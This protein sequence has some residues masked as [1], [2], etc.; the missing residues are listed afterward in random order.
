[1]VHVAT[2]GAVFIVLWQNI[3]ALVKKPFCKLTLMLIVATI[4]ACLLVVLAGDSIDSLL[5]GSLLGP[6]FI[7][8]SA[9]ICFSEVFSAVRGRVRRKTI[10][11]AVRTDGKGPLCDPLGGSP[12]DINLKSALTIGVLQA[13]AILPGV[14]R[15][16][17]TLAGG[18]SLGLERGVSARFS[19]LLSIPAILGAL[20]LQLYRI[21]SG[22]L[23]IPAGSALPVA[24]GCLTAFAAGLLAC[25]FMLGIVGKIRLYPFAAYT[26]LLGIFLLV[27]PL[28]TNH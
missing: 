3:W 16:G 1:M 27:Q 7:L 11:E 5:A 19:F 8:T 28:F 24:V 23:S 22:G 20:F 12:D 15:S 9:S 17:M 21:A 25:R 2:L 13:A 10:G 4:P 18:I 14:S 26:G 6:A